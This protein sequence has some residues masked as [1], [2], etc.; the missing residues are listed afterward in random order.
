L[1]DSHSASLQD[2]ERILS[3]ID[4]AAKIVDGD[5]LALSLTGGFSGTGQ[6]ACDAQRRVLEYVANAATR[7]WGFSM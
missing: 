5:K 6:A 2:E 3:V 7:R 4:R 1:I